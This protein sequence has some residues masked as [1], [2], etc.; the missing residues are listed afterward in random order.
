V[1]PTLRDGPAGLLRVRLG[2]YQHL[3]KTRTAIGAIL[4]PWQAP[5]LS[6]DYIFGSYGAHLFGY[7]A[8]SVALLT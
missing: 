5:E 1:Y 7:P 6:K 3:M 4:N 8:F 2:P